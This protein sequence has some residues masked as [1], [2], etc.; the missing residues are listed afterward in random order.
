MPNEFGKVYVVAAGVPADRVAA[1]EGAFAKAFADK[2]LLAEAQKGR[3]EIGPL[4][5]QEIQTLVR[6]FLGMSVEVKSKLQKAIKP[7]KK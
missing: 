5:G 2:E 3:L 7:G 1:L 4:L 6:E